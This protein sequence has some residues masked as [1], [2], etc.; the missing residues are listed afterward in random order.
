MCL[1]TRGRSKMKIHFMAPLIHG[2][3]ED[4]V[5]IVNLIEKQGHSVVTRHALE[6]SP[7]EIEKESPA[8]AELYAKKISTWVKKADA[9]VFEV[10][11]PDVSIGFEVAT[12]LNLS[13]PVIILYR[14]DKG[15]I[16]HALKGIHN[17]RMQLLSYD[18]NT[19]DEML[20]LALDFAEETGDIRFNFF[21]TPSINAYLDWIAK[22]KKLP[23]S[24]YLRNLIEKEMQD[25]QE[26]HSQEAVG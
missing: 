9:V 11:E 3:R 25:S 26:Y 17:D 6:R 21:V 13:K 2:S 7:V 19:L 12:A 4:Y 16:P 14:R 18:D 8:E 1:V 5:R 22:V 20:E 24:V 15:A 10:T 23:R